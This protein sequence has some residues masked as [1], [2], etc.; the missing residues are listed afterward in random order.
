MADEY[1]E[2][3]PEDESQKLAE[4]EPEEESI[5]YDEDAL[6][7]VAEFRKTEEGKRYLR[8][9]S[10]KVDS[11][12][13]ADWDSSEAF[14]ERNS[15]DWKLFTGDLPPKDYPYEDSANPNLPLYLE[16]ITR[17]CFRITGELFGDWTKV[18]GVIPVGA[19]DEPIA[20]IL[21]KHGNWQIAEQIPNFKREIGYR[22]VLGF[23]AFGDVVCHSYYDEETRLNKHEILTC[24][25]FVTPYQHLST[26]PD[27]SDCPHYTKV[28]RLYRHELEAKRD[29]W[30]DVDK[31]LDKARPSWDDEPDA[32][33]TE[34]TAETLGKTPEGDHHDKDLGGE[35]VPFTI[36]WYEGWLR[37][38]NQTRDRWCQVIQDKATKCILRLTIHERANW[39]D[40]ERYN[41]Q[42]RERDEYVQAMAAHQQMLM[43]R[44]Q[45]QMLLNEA[46]GRVDQTRGEVADAL[47]VGQMDGQHAVQLA[48]QVDMMAPPPLP[49]PPPEPMAPQWMAEKLS[50]P[51]EATG[52]PPDPA[53]VEPD[54]I[55]REP[56]Y[57]FAHEVCI[58]PMTGNLG[59][60]Y[61]RVQADFNRAANVALSQV[62]D[63]ATQAN[64]TSY[65][66]WGLEFEDGQLNLSPGKVNKVNGA[67]GTNIKD[68]FM[69]LQTGAASP[70]LFDIIKMSIEQSQASIQSPGVLSGESGKSGETKGG[71]MSRIE[72]ATKQLSVL[73]SKYADFV[74]RIL[75]NNAY[76]NSVFLREDE[77]VHVLNTESVQYEELKL[78]RQLYERNYRVQLKS[79]R[80]FVTNVERIQEAD[81]LVQM[82]LTIPALSINPVFGYHAIK[83]ALTA[84]GKPEF[85]RYLGEA[86]TLPVD[87]ATGKTVKFIGMPPPPPPPG[88]P[89]GNG[90]PQGPPQ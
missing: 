23:M 86:P 43:Q 38:P 7:L 71:I 26:M 18:F 45:Q 46:Q 80:R 41:A 61:G 68:H 63:S 44:E 64:A 17:L 55:R 22:G 62:T 12:Y 89:P 9:I 19:D 29:V 54:P 56:V 50:L 4:R 90:P 58:E 87:P 66:S 60:S 20:E 47:A 35:S 49:P 30:E 10:A 24:D 48:E 59:I 13:T 42:I 53:T 31:V 82:W 33:L 36:L 8:K 16:N 70:Q 75:V 74:Q 32:P 81:E 51:D 27:L 72:Q 73:T 67:I 83:G 21:S 79:D 5:I 76:L 34:A 14:R 57:L 65:I 78:G 28:L 37:L 85:V 77:M 52:L 84:R 39:Q 15:A 1:E 3:A 11:D 40:K 88:A 25:N 69:P 2:Y 6:N